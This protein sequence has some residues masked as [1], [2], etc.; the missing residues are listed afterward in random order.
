MSDPVSGMWNLVLTEAVFEIKGS[1]VTL[2]L[3][4]VKLVLII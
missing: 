2:F 3:K 1:Q 4:Y